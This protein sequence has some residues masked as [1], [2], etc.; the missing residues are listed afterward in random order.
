MLH[1]AAG[2]STAYVQRWQTFQRV[3]ITLNYEQHC[4][5]KGVGKPLVS[6]K[7][8][9]VAYVL[10]VQ[11]YAYSGWEQQCLYSALANISASCDKT[12]L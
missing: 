4:E 6:R 3:A 5:A 12:Q 2:S 10:G 11:Q 7:L 1:T 8:T 9:N